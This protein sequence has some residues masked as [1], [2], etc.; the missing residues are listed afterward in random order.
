MDLREIADVLQVPAVILATGRKGKPK[1]K[2]VKG[3][4][5]GKPSKPA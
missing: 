3:G 5:D 4:K 2:L 1:L